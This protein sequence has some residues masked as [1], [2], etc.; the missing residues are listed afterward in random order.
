MS[1]AIDRPAVAGDT[2]LQSHVLEALSEAVNYR[3]WLASLAVPWL[4]DDPIEVGSGI[5]DYAATWAELGF[6]MLATEADETRLDGLRRRFAD[7]PRV[8]VA[9]LHAP[10]TETAAHSAVVAYNVLEHLEDDVAAL[11]AFGG[12]V[13]PGG[14]VIVLV[15]AFPL[16]M[17][18]FDREIGHHRRYRVETLSQAVAQS[19]LDLVDVRY[20]NPVGLVAWVIGMRL[21]RRRPA[22]G[23]GLRIYDG[24]VPLL[25]RLEASQRPA[26]GQSAFVVARRRN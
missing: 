13:R 8:T 10:I 16:A 23:M 22:P 7:D 17:S 6:P 24:V 4:G 3:E 20:V 18:R 15:P 5:G 11:R 14:Y 2:V 9:Y 12:L 19:G 1:E 26:F 25:R 21:L